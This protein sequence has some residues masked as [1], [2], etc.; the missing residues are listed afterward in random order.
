[1]FLWKLLQEN[2]VFL[3]YILKSEDI[4][5]ILVPILQYL[6]E[7][8]KDPSQIGLL[9]LGT[10]ILLLLSGIREFSVTL[11]SP[12]TAKLSIG[13]PSFTGNYSDA[14]ILVIFR[15][16]VDSQPKLE[17]LYDCFFTILANISPY[18]KAL[19]MIT[20]IKLTKLFELLSE[21]NFVFANERN[22]RYLF[23][24]LETFN[25]FIQYQ[26]AGNY[27]LVYALI[28]NQSNFDKII[29]LQV[30]PDKKEKA[31]TEKSAATPAFAPTEEWLQSWKT[32][33]PI[34]TVVRLIKAVVPQIP[35]ITN[36]SA[37][38]EAK[39]LE[40]LQN[41]TV[42]GLLPVPHPILV[43]QYQQNSATN[44]WFTGYLWGSI[45][46]LNKNPP[47]YIGTAL[48]LFKIE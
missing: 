39:I 27:R 29:N 4:G 11:N 1:M 47:L 28:R 26:Y 38:D 20:C 14:L 18:I 15:L 22:H 2:T 31:S 45:F 46:L 16:I 7:A 21:S 13:L 44:A 12:F 24:L 23:F 32:Q 19:A 48:K 6:H 42:V 33:L 8:R 41:S 35:S 25:N 17:A 3:T 34:G 30:P 5:S 37:T 36:G 9:Q 10:F 40:Y 43:R